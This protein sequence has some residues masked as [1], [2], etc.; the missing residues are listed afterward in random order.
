M[1]ATV[2]ADANPADAPPADPGRHL[3]RVAAGLPAL[4]L[5][6]VTIN[7]ALYLAMEFYV[8]GEVALVQIFTA[9]VPQGAPGC[10][11][12]LAAPWG[13]GSH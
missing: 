9:F 2:A 5:L 11:G 7:A 10:N 4:V 6:I 13:Q 12:C 1:Q 8:Y 3:R